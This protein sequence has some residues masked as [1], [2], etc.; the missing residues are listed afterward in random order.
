MSRKTHTSRLR[1]QRIKLWKTN[2]NCYY[3]GKPTILVDT[4]KT[5]HKHQHNFATIEH[6]Y[7]INHPKRREPN[8]DREKRRVLACYKCNTSKAIEEQKDVDLMR[9]KSKSW[10]NI[11]FLKWDMISFLK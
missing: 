9:F 10:P 4:K 5:N 6:L 1:E 2:P 11:E 3:C 8:I 7:S